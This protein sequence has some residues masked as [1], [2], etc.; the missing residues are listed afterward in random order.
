[1]SRGARGLAAFLA[2]TAWVLLALAPC[3]A[4]AREMRTC[5][6]VVDGDTIVLDGGERVRL[7][8]VDTPELHHPLK[9]VQTFAQEAKDRTVALA[10]GR[11]VGL[12][13]DWQRQDRYGR[14]LA[15]VFLPDGSL[16]NLRLIEE[17]Y[18][19]AYLRYPFRRDRMERFRLAER[20]ARSRSRGL[21]AYREYRDR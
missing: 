21:W 3:A 14:T 19:F 4:V 17:G 5:V 11:R 10:E 13:Y 9:P 12:E 18:G 15:F 6:R 16:L 20:E 1:M 2:W 8:G 7:I